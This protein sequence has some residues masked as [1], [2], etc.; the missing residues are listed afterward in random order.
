VV[1]L[2]EYCRL[3]TTTFAIAPETL[4]LLLMKSAKRVIRKNEV[5]CFKKHFFFFNEAMATFKGHVTEV[6]FSERE[7]SRVWVVLPNQRICEARLIRPTPL[8]NPD[9]QTLAAVAQARAYERRLIRDY[10]L[11]PE[12]H[13]R[14]EAI[15]KCVAS[16]LPAA[17]QRE[18]PVF[19]Q[20]D[21]WSAPA[22]PQSRVH[23]LTRLDRQKLRAVPDKRYVTAAD[24]ANAEGEVVISESWR[25][26]VIEFDYQKEDDN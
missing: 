17:S 3:Y 11:I 23:Q 21:E 20:I 1:P 26:Q 25:N 6:L 24:V 4:A 18:M 10:T 7:Q 22:L 13:M 14:G 5:Q 2:E 15:E 8:L 19:P 9:P 16:A 12:T